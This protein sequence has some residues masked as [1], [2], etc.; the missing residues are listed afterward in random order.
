[1]WHDSRKKKKKKTSLDNLVHIDSCAFLANLKVKS[2][3][4]VQ[5]S[6]YTHKIKKSTLLVTSKKLN[7]QH[8]ILFLCLST[9]FFTAKFCP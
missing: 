1:M 3:N 8:E 2:L 9:T 7:N 5:A 6:H 4:I